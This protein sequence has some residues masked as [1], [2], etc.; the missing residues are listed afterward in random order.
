[1]NY[2]SESEMM[3]IVAAVERL[4]SSAAEAGLS[5]EDLIDLLQD[6]LNLEHVM[7]YVSAVLTKR[8]N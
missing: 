6:G 1:M 3:P 8:L 7:S 2:L 5:S 4:E